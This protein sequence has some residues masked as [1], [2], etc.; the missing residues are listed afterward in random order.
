MESLAT[1]CLVIFVIRTR[2]VPFVH[3]RP[4]P[5]LAATTVSVVAVGA[6]LP[7]SP[8]GD[9]LGFANLPIGFFAFL[10]AMVIAY[11]VLVEVGKREFYTHLAGGAP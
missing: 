1:Q 5:L 8:F 11:L 7:F 4:R 10:S 3:S 2:R 6:F 9:T